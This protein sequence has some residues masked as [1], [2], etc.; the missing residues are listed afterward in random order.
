MTTTGS[1]TPGLVIG[2]DSTG[3]VLTG[4]QGRW[5]R[6]DANKVEI[7][8]RIFVAEK[9]SNTGIVYMTLDP[10]MPLCANDDMDYQLALSWRGIKLPSGLYAVSAG[11]ARN[12]L[13][14]PLWFDGNDKSYVPVTDTALVSGMTRFDFSGWYFCQ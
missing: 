11:V 8:G 7:N 5:S 4:P 10:S 6:D 2:P 9:G 12:S 3:I 14:I 13:Q 1:F